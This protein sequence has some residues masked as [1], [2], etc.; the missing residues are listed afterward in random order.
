MKAA[1]Q[2]VCKIHERLPDGAILIFVSGQKEVHRL[3]RLLTQKYPQPV[4]KKRRGRKRKENEIIEEEEEIEPEIDFAQMEQDDK[5]LMDLDDIDA[6][7]CADNFGEDEYKD[8]DFEL[9]EPVG[10][11]KSSDKKKVPLYCLPLYSMMPSFLQRRVFEPIPSGQ[12]L[13]VVATNVA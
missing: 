8:D 7:D 11:Q 9:D 6:A 4:E 13:C 5:I 12:R 2:K 3:V 10:Q 1:F